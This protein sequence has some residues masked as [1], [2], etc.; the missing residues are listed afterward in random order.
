MADAVA[1]VR[2]VA[3]R[4]NYITSMLLRHQSRIES[5]RLGDLS[6]LLADIATVEEADEEELELGPDAGQAAAQ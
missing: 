5:L 3:Q 2:V 1:F 6:Q 4:Y